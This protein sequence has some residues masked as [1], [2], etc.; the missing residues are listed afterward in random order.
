LEN[1]RTKKIRIYNITAKAV[2]K[3]G[4]EALGTE[5]KRGTTFGSSTDEIFQTLNRNNKIG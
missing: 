1:K 3:F 5:E 4:S 2:L